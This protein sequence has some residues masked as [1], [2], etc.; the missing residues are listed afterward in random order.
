MK[1]GKT[2]T[3]R[4]TSGKK[5]AESHGAK[6]SPAT[7]MSKLA[8]KEP[9]Q[10]ISDTEADIKAPKSTKESKPSRSWHGSSEEIAPKTKSKTKKKGTGERKFKF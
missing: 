3:P 10:V 9:E 8:I 5:H 6:P 7:Q 2:K 4:I 1:T